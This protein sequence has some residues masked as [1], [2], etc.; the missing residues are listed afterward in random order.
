VRADC[1][2]GTGLTRILWDQLRSLGQKASL[3][4][5]TGSR[6]P[7]RELCKTEESRTSDFWEITVGRG[8][9]LAGQAPQLLRRAE[10]DPERAAKD[11]TRAIFTKLSEALPKPFRMMRELGR[12]VS[13]FVPR[14]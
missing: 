8:A 4:L 14:G 3:R 1:G 6:C 9:G 12:T 11:L 13:R 2:A 5:V 7:L 10:Q